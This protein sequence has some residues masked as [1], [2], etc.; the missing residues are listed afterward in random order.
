MP[1]KIPLYHKAAITGWVRLE[2]I[3]YRLKHS[4][5]IEFLEYAGK[6]TVVA[7]VISG[8]WSG[9]QWQ[10][11][12]DNR[13]KERHYRAW[14]L[15]NSARGS[16]GDGGRKDALQ[17]LNR[18]GVSLAA[19]PLEKAYLPGVSLEGANLSDANLEASDLT[20]CTAPRL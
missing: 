17:D 3:N 10:L 14:E 2:R 15:I 13:T 9:I 20:G 6:L 7:A 19:A 11:E 8:A 4:P 18:D 16:T 5:L 12:A 1:H